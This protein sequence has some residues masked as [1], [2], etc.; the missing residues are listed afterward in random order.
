MIDFEPAPS[1]LPDPPGTAETPARDLAA[2]L[3]SVDNA[4]LWTEE[5]RGTLA[6]RVA[7][8]IA[9]AR[10]Q[11]DGAYRSELDRLGAPAPPGDAAVRAFELVQAI[12]ECLYAA[13]I[14]PFWAA[15]RGAP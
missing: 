4:G 8:W 1:V 13:A 14:A 11:L 9:A 5:E 2:L 3:R 7:A 12:H 6:R 15:S 10:A